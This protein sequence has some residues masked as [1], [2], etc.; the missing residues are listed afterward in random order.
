VAKSK[1]RGAD[2]SI[3]R[4]RHWLILRRRLTALFVTVGIFA[5]FAWFLGNETDFG[6]QAPTTGGVI[7]GS[8]GLALL[9]CAVLLYVPEGIERARQA[10]RENQEFKDRFR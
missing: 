5:Q 7:V 8:I 4:R 1:P 2:A 3:R 6:Y 9:V 10:H